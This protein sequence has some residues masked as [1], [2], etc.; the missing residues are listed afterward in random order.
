MKITSRR[1]FVKQLVTSGAVLTAAPWLRSIGYAQNSRARVARTLIDQANIRSQLDRRLLGAFL[2]HLGRA[3]YTGVY[4]PGSPLADES[5]FRRDVI[6]EVKGLGVPNMRYP[7]GNFV[8]GY[9]WQDG[10]GPKNQRPTVLERAWN[11]LETN[12]FGTNEFMEWCKL[13]GTEPLL[14]FNLGTGSAEEAVAYVEYCNVARGTKW[15]DLRRQHGY[16]QPH[17]VKYWCLGNEMDGPWQMG[18]LT[19][20]EYGRKARDAAR[21]IRVISPNAQ[22]IACGSS[23]TILPTYL[24]WDRQVLEEC[25]DQVDGISLHNYYGNT[26]ALT[27]G[28]SARY[29]AM[30][31]D[32][33]R[34]IHEIAAV[35]DYVQGLQRSPKR[36]W[37]SFDEW[38]VWYRARGGAFANG[39]GKFAPRLLEEVYNLEDAL[40]VGGFV[41]TL[42][43]QSARVRVGCL[44]Q[45][46]NVI[47]PLV[48]N[49]TSVLRQSIYYPYAWALQFAHG[50]VLDLEVEAETYPIHAEGL[51][52]DFAREDQVPFVDV[53]AT[54]DAARQRAS[55]FL[56]NRDLEN[57][58]EF[59]VDWRNPTP[60]RVLTALT[61][62][63]GDL[64][65]A[66]T[67]DRPTL[68]APQ[69]LELPAV[70][71]KMTFKLPARSYSVVQ[72]ATA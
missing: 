45:I 49:E 35:C 64:K 6:A 55:V 3:V 2:E 56:L 12:Q 33:E 62:T 29:L 59:V 17:N 50:R 53:V 54:C 37:L 57:E 66:N 44:A 25:Y 10:V 26:A 24:E 71:A 51:R 4:E 30:N 14:G 67:F 20:P 41:N 69:P 42:L 60:A 72:F 38:N 36:L 23:N 58:R 34:Q 15:S 22:L 32:M 65:A 19:A 7:G 46:V 47:A 39:Q 13:V 61:L 63:G 9:H 16:E 1:Q 43:R 48:T 5:G 11:S 68:V 21:Q 40:L 8:S 70:G 18:R 27:G 28:S 52:A 31:L